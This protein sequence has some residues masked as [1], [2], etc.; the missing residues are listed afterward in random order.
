VLTIGISRL[1]MRIVSLKVI[2]IKIN[3]WR[4]KKSQA[5]AVM[6]FFLMGFY[7]NPWTMTV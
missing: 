1:I 5:F 6:G 3:V 7:S 4:G 2:P